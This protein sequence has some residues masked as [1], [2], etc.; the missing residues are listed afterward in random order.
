M[1]TVTRFLLVLSCFALIGISAREA[2]A[3]DAYPNRPLKL[4]VPFP[5]G[6]LTDVLARAIAERLGA[7][8]GQPVVAENRPGAGTLLGAELVAKSAPDGYTLLITTSS[9]F[10]VSPALFKAPKIV[11]LRDFK[12]VTLI[13]SVNFFLIGSPSLPHKT[14]GELLAHMKAN[15]GAYNYASVGNGSAHHIFTEDLKRLAG[16]EAQH[17]PY[18]GTGEALQDLIPGRVQ[19]MFSDAAVA[20]AQIQGGKVIAFGT[21]GAKQNVLRPEVPPIGKT[22]PGFDWQAWQGVSVPAGTPDE[23]VA[24]LSKELLKIQTSPEFRE[25][26]VKIGMEPWAPLSPDQ[27]A[28]FVKAEIPRWAEAVR[29]SGAKLD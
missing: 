7:A 21:S 18:K 8:L 12:P 23:I 6:G 1:K 5:P 2:A 24:R 15:P 10:G 27:F 29:V 17:V 16:V 28:D 26:L 4:V 3:N 14:L 25:F 11:P 22:I 19:I 13:G 20:M 9:T